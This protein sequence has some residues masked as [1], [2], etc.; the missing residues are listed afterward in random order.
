MIRRLLRFNTFLAPAMFPVYEFISRHIGD[1]LGV[2]VELGVGDSYD[3]LADADVS[4]V[5][6]LAYVE[7]CGPGRLPVE[8]IAAPVL[9]GPRYGGRPVYYS[10]IIVR[11]DSRFQ[12]FTDLRGATWCFNECLS[13][14]GYGVT[15]YHLVRLGETGGFFGRVVEAG[16]HQRSIGLVRDG[17]ADAAAIDSH[18]LSLALR[19]EPRLA[20]ELRVIASL[21]PSTIQPVTA[22]RWLPEEMR[23]E[24]REVLVG[25]AGDPAARAWLDRGLI[26]RFLP[27]GHGSY[28]DVRGMRDACV[29]AGF[30]TLR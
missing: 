13:H 15:R 4:F 10:D 1:R 17:E 14:S 11:R 28:D 20:D 21:G 6:G 22:G 19:A 30:R 26:E 29:A 27:V 8:P 5:C 16:W 3:R 7:L 25:M 23:Q 18:V 2:A 24:I 12:T 9:Q